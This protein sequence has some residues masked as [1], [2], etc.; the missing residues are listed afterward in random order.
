MNV[1]NNMETSLEQKLNLVNEQQDSVNLN[2]TNQVYKVL[3]ITKKFNLKYSIRY[4][5]S[6]ETVDSI[7]LSD[8]IPIT[9]K[10]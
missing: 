3:I 5:S 6:S 4:S 8:N 10:V 9:F 7:H 1:E 2:S